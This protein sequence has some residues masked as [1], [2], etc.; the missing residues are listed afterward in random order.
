MTYR[1]LNF[2]LL[3][4]YLGRKKDGAYVIFH[5]Y[6][7]AYAIYIA[8][9]ILK[10]KKE[11]KQRLQAPQISFA[12]DRDREKSCGWNSAEVIC[13][14]AF[15]GQVGGGLAPMVGN[16]SYPFQLVFN[17]LLFFLIS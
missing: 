12:Q 3:F 15:G 6:N 5:I 8:S 7:I 16:F 1:L 14:L 9:A 2:I 11:I 4:N 17:S 10:S 13:I